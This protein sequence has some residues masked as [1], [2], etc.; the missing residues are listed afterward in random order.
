[1]SCAAGVDKSVVQGLSGGFVGCA[2]AVLG[3]RLS[4]VAFLDED[5]DK[6]SLVQA[7]EV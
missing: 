4:H 5:V 6:C 2:G 7:A 3:G 1:M